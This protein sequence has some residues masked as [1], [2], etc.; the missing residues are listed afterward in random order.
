MTQQKSS[1]LNHRLFGALAA[2]IISFCMMT[3]SSVATEFATYKNDEFGFSVD[4]PLGIFENQKKS[5][6]GAGITMETNDGLV[7]F[8]AYGFM[9]GDELPLENVQSILLEDSDGRDVTYKR[10]KDNW[11]VLSGFEQEGDR[12]MIFYQRLQASKDLTS[13]SAFE[14]IYPESERSVFD[15]LIKRMSRSLTPPTLS[16]P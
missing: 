3:A 8:R 14:L 16:L 5:E 2:F 9:N 1:Y 12:K 4:F 13:F 15:P 11:I 6:A 7:E 10:I